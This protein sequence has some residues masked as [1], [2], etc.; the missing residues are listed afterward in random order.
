MDTS[1][2][3]Q[4]CVNNSDK[5]STR[6]TKGKD[7][8]WGK[9]GLSETSHYD[10]RRANGSSKNGNNISTRDEVERGE[11]KELF[12]EEGEAL[13]D[14]RRKLHILTFK[15]W[16]DQNK[17]KD[18]MIDLLRQH[19]DLQEPW[20]KSSFFITRTLLFGTWDGVFTSCLM[21]IVGVVIFLRTGWMVGYAGIGL[22]LLIV[23]L[24]LSV[25]LASVMSAVGICDRC[26]VKGGGVYFIVSHVLG[27]KVGGTIGLLYCLGH[28]AATAMYCT[29]FS[30]S[31]ASLVGWHN[32]WAIRCV[33]LVV[34]LSLLC[35]AISG[36]KWV[37]RFQLVLVLILA[38]AVLDFII[39]TLVHDDPVDGFTGFSSENF[40]SNTKPMFTG[41]V[42]FFTVFGVFFPAA[43]GVMSGVN[44][45]GD[46]KDPDRSIPVGSVAALGVSGGFYVVF[47]F[48]L[49]ATCTRDALRTDSMIMQK[50]SVIGFLFLLGLYVSSLS[51]ILGGVVGPPRVLQRIAEDNILPILKPFAKQNGACKEPRNAT[52]L[53]AFIATLFI[54]IGKL[55]TLAT[56]VTM[57][58]LL[59][60]TVINYAYFA[61]AMSYEVT[62]N[63]QAEEHDRQEYNGLS[64]Y[65]DDVYGKSSKGGRDTEKVP[66]IAD[67]QTY[68][69]Q[70]KD[71]ECN[72]KDVQ[73]NGVFN[74]KKEK[75]N[76]ES[77]RD[78]M[79]SKLIHDG[80]LKNFSKDED[81]D[82]GDIDK[83]GIKD[84]SEPRLEF[85]KN[86]EPTA[87]YA[88]I[89]NRWISLFTAAL[90]IILMFCISWSYAL[91]SMCIALVLYIFVSQYS[92]GLSHGVAADFSFAKWIKSPRSFKW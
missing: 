64:S 19:H 42:H 82:T 3:D 55:N 32:T 14:F 87:L 34:L 65:M 49:G 21:N 1:E 68:G 31:F 4:S 71:D 69:S 46:L 48:L 25:A 62:Q 70:H 81:T 78:E 18:N 88:K 51:S 43:C 80:A 89:C 61:L 28:A 20:W 52:I 15:S 5:S 30:E 22:S 63:R 77:A 29:G 38:I 9:Y 26:D 37:I 12:E 75:E 7:I 2:P 74:N 53:I 23:S 27:G 41:H 40:N 85:V 76:I 90:C 6:A 47:I 73:I 44:M 8:D 36:V 67:A 59:T 35:I 39:G 72:G 11:V 45:S 54:L 56:I 50:I 16:L 24:S 10:T 60:Y 13:H 58:F 66:L 86:K 84:K 17:D 92:P 79:N 57:P 91:A 83:E 33:S